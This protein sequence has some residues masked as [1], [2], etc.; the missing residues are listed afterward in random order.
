MSLRGDNLRVSTQATD[1]LKGVRGHGVTKTILEGWK[2]R[3]APLFTNGRRE[4]GWQPELDVFGVVRK[5]NRVNSIEEVA[6]AIHIK[7]LRVL[8]VADAPGKGTAAFME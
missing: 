6:D 8:N 5:E 4:I 7:P 3:R 2:I 1:I